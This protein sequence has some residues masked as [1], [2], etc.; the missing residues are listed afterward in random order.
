[1]VGSRHEQ[2][3]DV[4]ILQC[5]H[6]LD[7]FTTTVLTLEIVYSHPLDV[8]QMGHGDDHILHRN[9]IL[10]GQVIHIITNRRSSVITVFIRNDQYLI[11]DD[12]QQLVLIC[13]NGFQFLNPFHQLC[14][15]LLQLLSFQTGQCTQTHIYNGL[16]L[17]VIQTEA[18]HQPFLCHLGGTGASDDLDDLVDIIQRNEQAFQN[19]C[20]LLGFVQVVFRPSGDHILL[21]LQ[22]IFQKL[23]QAQHL[24]LIVH[25]RQ[26]DDTEGLLQ[27][28]MLVQ[29][30]QQHVGIHIFA[31]LNADAHTGTVRLIP[32]VGDAV[33]LL[34]SYQLGDLLDE[35]RLVDHVRDLRH[36]DAALAVGHGLDIGNRAGTDLAPAGSVC[37][38][39][40]FRAENGG[41]GGKIRAFDD[42]Q[43]LLDFCIS[44]LF[45]PVVDDLHHCLDD[46][47]QV[48]GRDIGGHTDGD[49]L[50]TVHQQVRVTGRQNNRF[51]LRLIE[52]WHKVYGIFV[53]IGQHLHGDLAQSCLCVSH[54]RC[55]VAVHGT[56][57]AVT[58]YQRISCGPLLGHID[59][60]TID[61][62]VTVRVVFTHRI[63]DN[64]RTFSVGLV[65]AVVQLDHGIEHSSL[66]R[67]QTVSYIRQCPGSD[68]AH[69]IVDIGGFHGLL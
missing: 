41:T 46:L 60:R 54:G 17:Y 48:V 42:G 7:T 59:Q 36:D 20:P 33:D 4:I 28:G 8:A 38:L 67:F 44:A 3:L 39:N 49:T 24:G 52:V 55:A 12:T 47:P 56:E 58:V 57:V 31:Q 15:F 16:C 21:M 6:A 35:S 63:T 40:A 50:G 62:A 1:M 2:I 10:G 64:T 32:Q 53:D 68:N 23:F 65:R 26:H 34:V 22:I 13:Q 11:P 69:G 9:E 14:I 18:L 29:L 5:L 25:Q 27:L 19:V 66:Y 51:F 45:H 43:K 30:V 61:G 37:F